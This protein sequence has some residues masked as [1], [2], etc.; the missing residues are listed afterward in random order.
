MKLKGIHRPDTV[1]VHTGD[2]LAAAA[3]RMEQAEVGVLAVVDEARQLVGIFPG[4]DL[5]RATARAANPA[6]VLASAH[7]SSRPET[8]NLQED[9]RTSPGAC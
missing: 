3:C 9:S 5:V 4:R 6:S 2:N 8:A 7:A 1:T